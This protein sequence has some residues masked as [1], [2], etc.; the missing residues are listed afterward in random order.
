MEYGVE[1]TNNYNIIH[2]YT[3]MA[4][5]ASSQFKDRPIPP[6]D[7]G[8][9]WI[10]YLLRHGPNSLKTA[11]VE[12]TWYQYL[13]LDVISTMVISIIFTI[14]IVYKLFKLLFCRRKIVSVDINKKR[15]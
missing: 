15:S 8:V 11:A 10:E 13:L 5:K 3:D 2:S 6:L 4:R 7:E 1:D 9:Y 14:W 12:L